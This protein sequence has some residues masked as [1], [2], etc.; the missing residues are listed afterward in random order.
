[1]HVSR[2]R[3]SVVASFVLIAACGGGSSSEDPAAPPPV[4]P[5]SEADAGDAAVADKTV[6]VSFVDRWGH[7]TGKL[8]EAPADTAKPLLVGAVFQAN[9]ERQRIEADTLDGGRYAIRGVPEAPYVL[10]LTFAPPP[11]R[12][13]DPVYV[14][15]YPIDGARQVRFG[16]DLWA[17]KAERLAPT[18]TVTLSVD[19]PAG[20]QDQDELELVSRRSYLYLNTTYEPP[21]GEGPSPTNVPPE[22][23]TSS[24]GWKLL[25]SDMFLPYGTVAT[26]MP[27]TAAG[28]DLSLYHSRKERVNRGGDPFQPWTAFDRTQVVGVL[29][30]AAPAIANGTTNTITGKLAAPA[31][32]T[33]NL[34]FD[35]KSFADAARAAY[36]P[37]STL[38]TSA[39]I[40]LVHEE[41]PGPQLF[42]SIATPVWKLDVRSAPI[43]LEPAC[44]PQAGIVCAENP[45]G[46]CINAITGQTLPP[47]ITLP[48]D[49]PRL[50]FAGGRDFWDVGYSAFVPWTDAT[51]GY[52]AT[53]SASATMYRPRTGSEAKVA[54]ELGPPKD[55]AYEM[56]Q[57]PEKLGEPA[58]V[59]TPLKVTFAPPSVGTPEYYEVLLIELFPDGSPTEPDARQTRTAAR[60]FTKATSVEIPSLL[61]RDKFTYYVRVNAVRDGRDF[62]APSLN[63]SDTQLRTGVFSV[64]FTRKL[65]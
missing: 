62:T 4:P 48:L 49:V 11:D 20:F 51:T 12:E 41:G 14:V 44:Y 64:P 6:Y 42:A 9:G 65:D 34:V 61:V 55:L 7:S 10:E 43:P 25:V 17:R 29:D 22:N 56:A 28:D 32:E 45:C 40:G 63:K 27:S 5:V 37:T 46:K 31:R 30:V 13:S 58:R 36:G 35:G 59:V 24:S 39:R 15:E 47:D 21:F 52:T 53:L 23:A 26:G 16:D 33:V 50:A 1:M 3:R 18:S 60:F 54:L 57:P 2:L 38:R 8:V 19:A